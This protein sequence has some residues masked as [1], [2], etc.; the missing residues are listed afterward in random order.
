MN[1][2]IKKL[3]VPFYL[4]EKFVYVRDQYEKHL[5]YQ[6]IILMEKFYM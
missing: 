2:K 1:S 6:C 4:N 3:N 5:R